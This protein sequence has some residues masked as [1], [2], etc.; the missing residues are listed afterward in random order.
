MATM[1]GHSELATGLRFTNDCQRLISASGDGCIFVW[2]VPR[3]MVITMRA[4]LSQQAMRQG[5]TLE[6]SEETFTDGNIYDFYEEKSTTTVD[7]NYRFSI[8][9]LPQWA[10]KKFT[11]DTSQPASFNKNVVAPKGR[12]AQ[13]AEHTEKSFY[14]QGFQG[15]FDSDG[16]KDSSLDSGTDIKNYS[17]KREGVI[18]V[19]KGLISNN[20]TIRESRRGLIMTDDSAIGETESTA[21]DADI[22]SDH[23]YGKRPLYYPSNDLP[24]SGN[25]YTVTNIDAD[26]LRK[27]QRKKKSMGGSTL[28]LIQV[29]P[30]STYGSNDSEEDDDEASTPSGD[31]T[32][33]NPMSLFSVSSESLDQLVNRERYLQSTFESMSG[34]ESEL[35]P[36]GKIMRRFWLNLYYFT[37]KMI[38]SFKN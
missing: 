17:E 22:D 33:R 27:S 14:S 7:S 38:F 30:S 29:Q 28:P 15:R 5:R 12:W 16:S 8:G 26:E 9:Q 13:R 23:E 19:G 34:A 18:K 25:E 21:H 2:R 36:K 11:E 20:V 35:T 4:R 6:R 24:S 3:D 31:N 1:C 10:K 37:R 32:D